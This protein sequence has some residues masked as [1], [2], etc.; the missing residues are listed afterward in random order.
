MFGEHALY[1]DDKVV[2]LVFG[3]ELFVKPTPGAR[4]FAADCDLAPP[5]RCM[6]PHIL[7]P[8]DRWEDQAWLV[9]L[10]RIAVAELP[11]PRPKS[12]RRVRNGG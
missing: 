11:A 12:G 10:F 6:R 7:V 9:Q 1:C 3:D 2:A 8:G 4:T 5:H